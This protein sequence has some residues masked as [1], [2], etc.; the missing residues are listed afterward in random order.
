MLKLL[1]Y[2]K[3]MRGPCRTWPNINVSDHFLKVQVAE[4]FREAGAPPPHLQGALPPPPHTHNT[5]KTLHKTRPGKVERPC[6]ICSQH[7]MAT[8]RSKTSFKVDLLS[9]RNEAIVRAFERNV[10]TSNIAYI[11]DVTQRLVQRL[12]A[13]W[14]DDGDI[15]PVRRLGR[16]RS[17]RLPKTL[18]ENQ[19]SKISATFTFKK[20]PHPALTSYQPTIL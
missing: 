5:A 13:S 1:K 20:W 4:I 15:A 10:N 14:F 8:N 16:P 7:T 17:A 6:H 11:L 3:L 9:W 18:P 19:S 12:M 2:C